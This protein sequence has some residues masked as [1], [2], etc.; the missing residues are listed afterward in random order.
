MPGNKSPGPDGYTW[1]FYRCCWQVIKVDVLA[2][3]QAL[4]VGHDQHFHAI[5][6]AYITLIPKREGAVD[7]RDFRPISLVH[8]F[9]KLVAKTLAARLA[10]RIGALVDENH[11]I[12]IKK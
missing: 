3:L 7:L 11:Y 5:N 2:A 8:S 9:A 12:F 10:L 1:E 4:F 6:G